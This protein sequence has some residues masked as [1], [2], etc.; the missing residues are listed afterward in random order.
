MKIGN[1]KIKGKIILAPMAGVTDKAFRKICRQ[2]GAAL[3]TTEMVSAKALNFRDKKT[4]RLLGISECETPSCV[5]IF[6][7]DPES[8]A[9]GAIIAR[10]ISGCDII[11]IN[12]GCPAPK[13]VNNGDGSALMKDLNRAQSI[14]KS[15]RNVVNCPVTIKFRKGW[16]ESNINCVE[17]A[18]MCECAGAD[19]V[20]IH[21]R[22]RAQQYS[23]NA[24]WDIIAQIKKAVK[25]PVCAN[26]DVFSPQDVV[27]IIEHTNAD[28]VMIGRGALGEPWIFSRANKL[29]ETG[30]LDCEPNISQ[31]L[32]TALKQIELACEDKGEHIA[33]LEARKHVN[34][35]LKGYSGLKEFKKRI[36]VLKSLDELLNICEQIK[37]II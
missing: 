11:D 6:G 19:M 25:I 34:W 29:I 5:Q 27:K 9:Q 21:G 31:R 12:M 35:Y 24:D 10:E 15:V 37:S 30:I 28:L 32:D 33:I 4:F 16:D 20:T 3:T 17:F 13:I 2:H 1:I 14:I 7:S 36:S 26:G 22:T 23:G 18:K 8:M